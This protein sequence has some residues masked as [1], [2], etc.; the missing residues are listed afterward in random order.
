MQSLLTR[1]GRLWLS[2]KPLPEPVLT[3]TDDLDRVALPP[4]YAGLSESDEEGVRPGS[5]DICVVALENPSAPAPNF[6]QTWSKK[7]CSKVGTW[8]QTPPGDRLMCMRLALLPCVLLLHVLEH[9]SGDAWMCKQWAEHSGRSRVQAAADGELESGFLRDMQRVAL[10]EHPDYS[11]E[12]S[13]L[14]SIH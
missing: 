7:N 6:W 5:T 1:A 3:L 10:P 11:S 13:L 4:P 8:L 9:V 2:G 14:L 12:S